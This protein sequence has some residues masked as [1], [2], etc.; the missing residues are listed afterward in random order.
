[1]PTNLARLIFDV[2]SGSSQFKVPKSERGGPKPIEIVLGVAS[3]ARNSDH[4]QIPL[5]QQ[6]PHESAT[7][8][9]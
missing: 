9:W 2:R 5:A 6:S 3:T 4:K 7:Q 8:Q 1:M